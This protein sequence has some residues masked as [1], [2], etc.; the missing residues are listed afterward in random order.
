MLRM[1]GAIHPPPSPK[2]LHGVDRHFTFYL[3]L[4]ADTDIWRQVLVRIF[5][6][7]SVYLK[8]D[9][10]PCLLNTSQT[11]N[12]NNCLKSIFKILAVDEALQQKFYKP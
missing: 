2:C 8:E 9:D 12:Q 10:D 11:V 7:A 3:F 5:N 1:S 4:T 6:H